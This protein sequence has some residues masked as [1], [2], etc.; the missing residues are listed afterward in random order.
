VHDVLRAGPCGIGFI[1]WHALLAAL[2]EAAAGGNDGDAVSDIRQLRSL[3]S[4]FESEGF[5][6]LA[7]DELEDRETP[8][9]VMSLA[10]LAGDIVAEAVRDGIVST[11]GT[12]SSHGV[13][14]AG[15]YIALP[16]AGAWI[17]LAHFRWFH[18]GRS[19]LWLN[20]GT[21]NWGRAKLLKNALRAWVISEPPR[22]YEADDGPFLVPVFIRPGAEKNVVVAAAVEQLRL[23]DAAMA[24]AGVP[25]MTEA[26]PAP[27]SDDAA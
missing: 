16:R 14:W 21:D 15:R 6:P 17:G 25:L 8:R 1:A 24:E 4:T 9:R 20:F 3:C 19:P 13:H 2:E 10:D 12:R 5:V 26:A 7:R 22:A 27:P 18:H 11:K 23:L